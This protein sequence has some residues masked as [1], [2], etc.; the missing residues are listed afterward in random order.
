[1]LNFT[2]HMSINVPFNHEIFFHLLKIL[3]W[4]NRVL[5]DSAHFDV[6]SNFNRTENLLY[7]QKGKT[8]SFDA[9]SS[10]STLF[11]VSFLFLFWF[12]KES[13]IAFSS[14]FSA[15][16]AGFSDCYCLISRRLH[17]APYDEK[18]SLLLLIPCYENFFLFNCFNGDCKPG[19]LGLIFENNI[20]L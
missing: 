13:Q 1:M 14:C 3:Y 17:S 7:R 16:Y 15:F 6:T 2:V 12:P 19:L 9:I 20:V 5:D 18:T 4:A 8:Q 11:F 10:R